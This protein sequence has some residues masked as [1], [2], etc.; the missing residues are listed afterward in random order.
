MFSLSNTK[1][2]YCEELVTYIIWKVISGNF[3]SIH[4]LAS[5]CKCWN[6]Y[7]LDI[8][9]IILHL[10]KCPLE[11]H[12][13][14]PLL[15]HYTKITKTKISTFNIENITTLIKNF[16]I[17]N[18]NSNWEN[19][20]LTDAIL[21]LENTYSF[22][23]ESELFLLSKMIFDSAKSDE[24]LLLKISI[25]RKTCL[26]F[27]N[28]F[29]KNKI[30]FDM[31]DKNILDTITNN[32]TGT[33]TSKEIENILYDDTDFYIVTMDNLEK[34]LKNDFRIKTIVSFF[35]KTPQRYNNFARCSATWWT[36]FVLCY[37]KI[38]KNFYDYGRKGEIMFINGTIMCHRQAMEE[39]DCYKKIA[40]YLMTNSCK[41]RICLEIM[42][43]YTEHIKFC[44][45]CKV[46]P[47]YNIWSRFKFHQYVF[48]DLLNKFFKN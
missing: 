23:K 24:L 39:L 26:K 30:K 32:Y 18:K 10:S 37:D 34:L 46:K 5:V 25:T 35:I 42:H 21:V 20:K 48:G 33:Y 15:F 36:R 27:M 22:W 19:Y 16:L 3:Q 47:C 6:S 43:D 1:E 17:N 9:F 13:N 41:M 40:N 29:N 38:E 14:I 11:F 7:L 44:E 4:L 45:E 8:N 12:E 2:E 28:L 31:P